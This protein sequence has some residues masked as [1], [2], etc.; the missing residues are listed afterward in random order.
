VTGIVAVE[1]LT[2]GRL[3]FV[4]DTP[5]GLQLFLFDGDNAFPVDVPDQNPVAGFTYSTS[6]AHRVSGARANWLAMDPIAPA[7][8][9]RLIVVGFGPGEQPRISLVNVD[10]GSTRVLVELEGVEPTPQRPVT[11]GAVGADLVFIA[12]GKLWILEDAFVE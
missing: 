4:G 5:E 10:T 3:A 8:D 6:P 2:D 11:A 9:G 12:D 7:P 1:E